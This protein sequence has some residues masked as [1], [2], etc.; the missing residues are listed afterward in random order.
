MSEEPDVSNEMEVIR[1]VLI[2]F[3]EDQVRY[4][5]ERMAATRWDPESAIAKRPIGGV[6]DPKLY[7]RCLRPH[8][9]RLG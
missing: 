5:D 2:E 4:I 8:G 7:E 3:T 1:T 6:R 9:A